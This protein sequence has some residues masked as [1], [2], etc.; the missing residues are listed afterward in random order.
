MLSVCFETLFTIW[1]S[2]CCFKTVCIFVHM[3]DVKRLFR[4]VFHILDITRLIVNFVEHVSRIGCQILF[5]TVFRY[6]QK[7]CKNKSAFVFTGGGKEETHQSRQA[8]SRPG[9]K[10]ITST[11]VEGRMG[12][13]KR[14][15]PDEMIISLNI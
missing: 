4:N 12:S 13:K 2:I 1:L 14:Q 6:C 9:D 7:D 11:Y 5:E 8:R 10:R 15:W 3:L